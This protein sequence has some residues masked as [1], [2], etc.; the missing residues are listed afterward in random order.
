MDSA[1]LPAYS[2]LGRSLNLSGKPVDAILVLNR[3]LKKFPE[4]DSIY[5]VDRNIGYSYFLIDRYNESIEHLNRAY[6]AKPLESE[7]VLY[8][9]QSY[10]SAKEN[11]M[12]IEFWKKYIELEPD[13]LKVAE[14]REHMEDMARQ[15]FDEIIP[16]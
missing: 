3:A 15:Y 12:S 13:S 14:A 6:N 11:V 1:F 2:A 9:A 8:L 7:T 10:E 16:K 5:L 4:S